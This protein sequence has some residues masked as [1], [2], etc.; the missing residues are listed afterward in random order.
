MVFWRKRELK[1]PHPPPPLTSSRASSALSSNRGAAPSPRRA[2]RKS[3][4][5]FSISITSAVLRSPS[6]MHLQ[7]NKWYDVERTYFVWYMWI[8]FNYFSLYYFE[9]NCIISIINNTAYS[10]IPE[11]AFSKWSRPYMKTCASKGVLGQS[12]QTF[13]YYTSIDVVTLIHF[14][15]SIM[16]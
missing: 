9:R 8:V 13:I 15:R 4:E 12:F 16:H 3:T 11:D 10:V 1:T 14:I 6:K 5:H 2:S 7:I